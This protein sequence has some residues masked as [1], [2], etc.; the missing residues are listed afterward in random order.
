MSQNGECVDGQQ[1][2]GQENFMRFARRTTRGTGEFYER[3]EHDAMIGLRKVTPILRAIKFPHDFTVF[4]DK[5]DST[6][7]TKLAQ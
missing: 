2:E 4:L 7:S 6:T 1:S 5:S 3:P